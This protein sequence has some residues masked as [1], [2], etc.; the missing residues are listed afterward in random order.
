MAVVTDSKE[1]FPVPRLDLNAAQDVAT[2]ILKQF[3]LLPTG[4]AG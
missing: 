2:F 1:D 3:D 4:V